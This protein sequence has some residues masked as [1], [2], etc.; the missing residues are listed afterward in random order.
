MSKILA[1]SNSAHNGQPR[2]AHA[3]RWIKP[4]FGKGNLIIT[5]IAY[6]A[7]PSL[8]KAYG[9]DYLKKI[10]EM[11]KP[12]FNE[13]GYHLFIPDLKAGE[14]KRMIEKSHAIAVTGGNSFFLLNALYQY[15]L[16][17]H[18][19]DLVTIENVP[20]LGWSAGSNVLCPTIMTTNDM[21]I[22]QPPSF[23]ALNILPFQINPHFPDKGKDKNPGAET[24][25][26]RLNELATV[27]PDVS[28]VGLRNGSAIEV[29]GGL[30]KL[31]GRK[32]V[33]VFDKGKIYETKDLLPI[34]DQS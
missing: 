6:A 31:L 1:L 19:R 17:N 8:Q 27:N 33:R 4:F 9:K 29:D 16:L 21:P 5:L 26:D 15:G 12:V 24:R 25:E 18:I 10:D 7:F 22:I 14:A 28:I 34:Y 13:M 30:I 32:S 20:Y 3:K 11:F 23:N 2:L